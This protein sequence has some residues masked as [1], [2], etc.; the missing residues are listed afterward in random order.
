MRKNIAMRV[1]YGGS[2]MVDYKRLDDKRMSLAESVRIFVKDGCTLTLGGSNGRNTMAPVYEIIRQG[3]KNLTIIDENSLMPEDVL[4]GAGCVKRWESSYFAISMMNM[5]YNFRRAIENGTI[6]FEDYSNY[7]GS[8]RFLA[9]A[10]NVPFMPT[11][12]L[13]GTDIPKYNKNIKVIED[14]YSGRPIALVPAAQPDVAIIPVSRASKEGNAQ[15]WG[16]VGTDELRAKA[17]KHTVVICEEL[18]SAEDIM[19]IPN[20]TT[21][22]SYCVDAVV[23]LPYNCHPFDCYGYYYYDLIFCS[24]YGSAARTYDGF[25][26][27]L[28]EWVYG[29]NDHEGYCEKVGWDRL[30]RLTEMAHK[31][32]RIPL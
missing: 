10:L 21:I 24:D 20:M 32:A 19:R 7:T 31:I 25:R 12:S 23:E 28:D 8:L 1:E 26:R 3:K 6:E 11:Q 18:I 9:G 27:W 13:L 15:I 17:S 22:P 29:V 5:S 4:I 30:H 14:P 2:Q 16:H